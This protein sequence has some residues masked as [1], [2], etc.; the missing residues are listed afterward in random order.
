VRFD[1]QFGAVLACFALSG[2]AA[3]L[4][5]TAWLREFAFV[6][7]TA[8]LAVISVLAAYMA[9]LAIGAAI[10][11]R[12]ASRV[13][14]PVLVYGF[15]ELAIGACAIAVPWAIR[16]AMKIYVWAFGSLAAPPDEG[17][18]ASIVFFLVCAFVILSIPTC[19]MGVTLPLLARYAV[20]REE[21]IGKRIGT[22]YAVNTAGAVAGTL[23]A[24]FV[25]LPTIGLRSTVYAG[26][27][28]NAL[29]FAVAALLARSVAA[30]SAA[31]T[32]SVQTRGA[33]WILPL[34]AVSGA[35]SFTY[36]VLWTRLLGQVLGGSVYA[37]ATMLASFLLG[38]TLGSAVASRFAANPR[39]SSL[40]FTVA[41]LGAAGLSLA[42]F[43]MLDSLPAWARAIGANAQG[44]LLANSAIA[45]A[46]LLPGALCFGAT[47]PFAVRLL[48]RDETEAAAAS[49]RVYAWNTTG[50]I[51]GALSA[52]LILLPALG[53]S[54]AIVAAAVVN[55]MLALG[56]ALFA[57]P[58]LRLAAIAAVVAVALLAVFPPGPPWQILRTY[59]TSGETTAGDVRY[60]G[61][62]R[63]ATVLLLDTG[64]EWRLATNGLPEAGI[65]RAGMPS[66]SAITTRWLGLLPVLARPEARS[67]LLIGL[68][69]GLTL[70]AIP[71]IIENI[72]VIELEPEVIRAN[73]AVATERDVDP[74]ADPRVKLR[75]N[76]AR[77]ALLLTDARYDVIV[78]Q[79]SHPW[80]AGASHLYTKEFFALVRDHLESDGIFSQW[81]GMRFVD[82]ELLRILVA[83]LL[84]TFENVRAYQPVPASMVFLAS[85][86]PI[87]MEK[88]VAV[89]LAAAPE[90]FER[91]GIRVPEDIAT[92]LTL[93]EKAT[94]AFASGAIVNSDHHNVLATRSPGLS[95]RQSLIGAGPVGVLSPFD[96]LVENAADLDPG[97]LVR[98]LVRTSGPERARRFATA[99][100]NS[101]TRAALL[102]WVDLSANRSTSARNRFNRALRLDPESLEARAGLLSLEKTRVENGKE[103][104]AIAELEPLDDVSAA[105]VDGWR[106]RATL[107]W[108]GLR[109]LEDRLAK[110]GNYHPLFFEALQL[111][112][113]WRI[114]IGERS[115]GAE[116]LDMIDSSGQSGLD[117]MILRGR[118]ALVAELPFAVIATVD[119]VIPRVRKRSKARPFLALLDQLPKEFQPTT[120]ESLRIR[121]K[122]IR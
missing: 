70:Q 25:L 63:S 110:A 89:A 30:T 29:V 105:I 14:R 108:V 99:I 59:P 114:E 97:Y 116:A 94:R 16:A 74:L 34:M 80:T 2:F 72:D 40:G 17:Q 31:P 104:P 100:P 102:G 49:A 73:Q 96:S 77:G 85:D 121:L 33:N 55:L 11:A 12:V 111:R 58:R 23:C 18:L 112:I 45:A 83:T 71:S 88:S 15:L 19:L 5:Q 10:A 107:D 39:R 117:F 82:E 4:Y 79:P 118:A 60:F 24:A 26:A 37:F 9:G 43:A 53:F 61:V 122:G 84:A 101:V 86:A 64:I 120:V 93:D 75:A 103:S 7:G 67:L 52:G 42:A 35:T 20:R 92:G 91:Y 32:R 8:E 98:R 51:V 47:Y 1:R 115:D 56:A 69:G 81:I 3:L 78:S 65:Q 36:E 41:Q 119:A 113:A 28:T 21:D 109:A 62:G 90:D 57:R 95:H 68:G 44:S 76:D 87:A 6:F 22:L 13:R 54:G 38:I 48:A 50:A 27:A 66:Q 46:C 106:A